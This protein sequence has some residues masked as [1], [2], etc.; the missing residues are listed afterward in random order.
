MAKLIENAKD[1]EIRGVIRFLNA[2]GVKACE[3][4]RQISVVYGDRVMSEG[5]VR[6][7]VRMFN[8]G[9]ENVHDEPRS[10]RPS[11]VTDS[12]VRDINEKILENRRFTISSLSQSFSDISCS[13]LYEIVSER[14]GFRKVCARWVPKMLTAEHKQ[15]RKSSAESFLQRYRDEGEAFLSQIVTGDETWVHYDTRNQRTFQT[16]ET[17]EFSSPQKV[18]N[19]FIR[20][21]DDVH[22]VLGHDWNYLDRLFTTR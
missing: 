19:S 4:S 18:Q 21:E 22:R 17:P 16:M 11:V 1:C 5:M 7:W 12:L 8:E 20:E 9:R 14:L 6:K 10:G 3:I 13:V 15:K 2:Q